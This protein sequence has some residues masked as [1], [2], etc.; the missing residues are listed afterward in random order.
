VTAPSRA[1]AAVDSEYSG[2]GDPQR[3]IELLWGIQRARRGPKPRFAVADITAVAI[4]I[5]DQDGL[6]ALSMRRV[7]EELGLT[8]MSLYGYIPGKAELLDLMVDQVHGELR[9]PARSGTGWRDTMADLARQNW[10]LHRTHPWLLQIA[11][12]RPLLGPHTTAKY[13]RELR[14]VDGI[15][16]SDIDMDLVVSL[17]DDFVHGAARRAVE[18]AQAEQHTGTSDADWWQT[19]QPLLTQVLD[20]ERYPTAVRVGTAAGTEHDGAYDPARS[21]EFGLQ[22]ILDSITTLIQPTPNQ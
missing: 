10:T 12:S 16:L 14:A 17:V 1:G 9:E 18:A 20:P 2:S 3:T 22:R 21:F 6:V 7:A 19:Y 11:T 5:A 15:G 8:A 13:D 4:R